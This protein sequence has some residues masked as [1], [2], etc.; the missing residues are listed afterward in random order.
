MVRARESDIVY[1]T[2]RNGRG[3][4]GAIVVEPAAGLD[5]AFHVV[6]EVFDTVRS[7]GD[8]AS[9][10][11]SVSTQL[12]PAG[13]AATFELTFDEPG[14]YPFVSHKMGPAARGAL[15]RIVAR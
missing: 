13:G 14:R 12:V 10:L 4:Y 2:L 11:S 7:D 1:V 8:P 15:G 3:M 6:G 9:A 5:S